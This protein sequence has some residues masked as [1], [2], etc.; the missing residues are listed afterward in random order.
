MDGLLPSLPIL[1][2]QS[3]SSTWTILPWNQWGIMK[4]RRPPGTLLYPVDMCAQ[5]NR[6][7]NA[8]KKKPRNIECNSLI[9]GFIFLYFTL[10]IKMLWYLMFSYQQWFYFNNTLVIWLSYF[11]FL[12]LWQNI[13]TKA[14]QGIKTVY[15]TIPDYH[16]LSVEFK[17]LL[18]F[19]PESM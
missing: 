3:V 17:Q 8:Q 6:H 19:H 5:T 2:P 16:R 9:Y 1:L 7:T 18:I 10:L 13:T 11:L 12:L 4:Q 14:T 15:L